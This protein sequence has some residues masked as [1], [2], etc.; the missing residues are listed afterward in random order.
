MRLCRGYDLQLKAFGEIRPAVM[1][2]DHLGAAERLESLFPDG[3]SRR[4]SRQKRRAIGLE[5]GFFAG[6]Q[7]DQGGEN[8]GGDW[9]RVAWIEP[10]VGVAEGMHVGLALNTQAWCLGLQQSYRFRGI[11]N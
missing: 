6:T 9:L 11:N 3:N 7:A 5:V 1:Y 10:I 4:Q 8:R 2:H